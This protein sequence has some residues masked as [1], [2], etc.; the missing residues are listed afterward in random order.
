[1]YLS[2]SMP[3]DGVC[4]PQAEDDETE[5]SAEQRTHQFPPGDVVVVHIGTVAG[6]GGRRGWNRNTAGGSADNYVSSP[7]GG[8]A[9]VAAK[10]GALSGP[11]EMRSSKPNGERE[12]VAGAET[13]AGRRSGILQCRRG[14]SKFINLR[15]RNY[16]EAIWH[17]RGHFAGACAHP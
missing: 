17:G 1:M 8:T 13:P 9:G 16:T 5:S 6:R 14:G 3:N 7:R 4:N 15:S 2:L 12:A 10:G 11:A